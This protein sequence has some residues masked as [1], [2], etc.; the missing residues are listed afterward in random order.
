[1]RKLKVGIIDV[2]HNAP[3]RAL[4]ARVMHA[5]LAG[6]MAQV[7]AVWCEELGH[8]VQFVC[9]TGL[10]D[11]A[12]ELPKDCDAVFIS[13]FTQAAQLTYALSHFFRSQGAVT[14]LGGPHARCYPE[15]AARY[16]DYVLGFTDRALVA[17]VLQDCSQYRPRGLQ[18]AASRQPR[19][20][21]GVIQ[22][23]KF[24]EPTLAKAPLLKIVPMIGS[25]GCP[26][27]CPFCID[28]PVPYQ[29]LDLAPLQDDLRFL[30]TRFAHPKVSWHD[31][32]FGV[33]FDECLDAIEEAVRPGSV[34]FIAETSLALLTEPRLKRLRQ[35]G[36]RALLPGVESWYDLGQKS[37]TGRSQGKDKV[38][39]VAD[40]LNM[41]LRYVPYVQAN[42]V[43]GL[44]SDEGAE[45]FELTKQFID[46]AP[47][48]FPGYSLLTAFGRAA[49]LNLE[50]Q[51]SNRVLAFPFHFLDNNHAMN[52][53]PLNYSWP[54]FYDHLIDLTRYTFSWRTMFRRFRVNRRA[55]PRWMNLVRGISSEGFGRLRHYQ[56]LRRLLDTDFELRAFF[57]G[58]TEQVPRYYTEILRRE[59]GQLWQWLPDG[60]VHHDHHAYL[61][62]ER[63][64]APGPATRVSVA[65][66]RT[67]LV[68]AG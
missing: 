42:F 32:N 20:L 50:Y 53:R 51:L 57:E 49:P 3:T 48:V 41:V 44:D 30:Q 43:L 56:H 36:C 31:P 8:E 10:E 54:D 6:I 16:F 19:A 26:Y 14:I 68:D 24:I 35:N 63:S 18:L 52:V 4:Y 12:R 21:P 66:P 22:R 62:A 64:G 33:R 29:A 38:A 28:A 55:I 37:R 45:P 9:Y 23:W 34:E 17:D 27:T 15:D 7:I 59:L 46:L 25:L 61:K 40:H 5:N 58:E 2:V 11:L 39:R 60:A 67:G 65:V 47:G 1:M 13:G